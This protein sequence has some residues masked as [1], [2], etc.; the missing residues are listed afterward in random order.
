MSKISLPGQCKGMITDVNPTVDNDCTEGYT[1]SSCWVNTATEK[2]FKCLDATEGAAIWKDM[3]ATGGSS[4]SMMSFASGAGLAGN[5]TGYLAEWGSY[6]V[7]SSAQ[8]RMP[9]CTLKRLTLNVS[10]NTIAGDTVYTVRK[11]GVDTGL[12]LTFGNAESGRKTIATDVS[13]S[14]GDLMSL[15]AVIGGT[16]GSSIFLK[17]ASLEVEVS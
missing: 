11:N 10:S 17:E 2:A 6:S 9:A 7:E 3:T 14:D 12:T 8:T 16:G 15:E 13:F 1:P 5:Q 4:K